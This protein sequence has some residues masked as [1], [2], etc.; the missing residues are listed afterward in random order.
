MK[1]YIK[2]LPESIGSYIFDVER[3]MDGKNKETIFEYATDILD[4]K[5]NKEMGDYTM[6]ETARGLL[7]IDNGLL[8]IHR[9]KQKDGRRQEYYVVPGGGIEEGE[10]YEDTVKREI[11]EELGIDVKPVRLLYKQKIN[12]EVH[13]YFLCEYLSGQIGTGEGPEFNSEA[14][15]VRGQYIPEVIP[16]K[17][18]YKINLQEPLKTV[19]QVDLIK[20]GSIENINYR[21]ISVDSSEKNTGR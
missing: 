21:D 17:E 9:I 7:V 19:L 5:I 12:N 1:M 8:L 11:K 20:Y 6:R 13:N 3:F 2:N 14:Y 18:L 10:S 4:N 16:L 15:S